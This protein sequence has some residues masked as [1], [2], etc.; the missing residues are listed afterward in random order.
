VQVV[1]GCAGR[2]TN[3]QLI[4]AAEHRC[5]QIFVC[6]VLISGHDDDRVSCASARESDVQPCGIDVWSDDGLVDGF[7]LNAVHSSGVREMQVLRRVG[8]RNATNVTRVNRGHEVDAVRSN[9]SHDPCGSVLDR[10]RAI[11]ASRLNGV[12]D[13]DPLFTLSQR[14]AR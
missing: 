2:V 6:P 4:R 1:P 8:A 7:A 11:V 10:G 3:A 5:G 14:A 12:A 13:E 9:A